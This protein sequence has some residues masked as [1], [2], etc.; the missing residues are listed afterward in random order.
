MKVA[1]Q[2]TVMPVSKS[3]KAPTTGN[4]GNAGSTSNSA[5]NGDI[6]VQSNPQQNSNAESEDRAAQTS[7]VDDV[8]ASSEC[9]AL[10]S[11]AA[12]TCSLAV[13]DDDNF[14]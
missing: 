3:T 7:D 2:K 9:T 1:S 10:C 13:P 14:W 4:T 11:I 6:P 8:E 12:Q 5:N